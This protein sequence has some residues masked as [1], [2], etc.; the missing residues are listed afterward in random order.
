[1]RCQPYNS[2]TVSNSGSTNTLIRCRGDVRTGRQELEVTSQSDGSE[3]R[4]ANL[5]EKSTENYTG[6]MTTAVIDTTL[7]DLYFNLPAVQLIMLYHMIWCIQMEI[8]ENPPLWPY[9]DEYRACRSPIIYT[10]SKVMYI[11]PRLT[12]VHDHRNVQVS[13]TKSFL[14][15]LVWCAQNKFELHQIMYLPFYSMQT[16]CKKTE[17]VTKSYSFIGGGPDEAPYFDVQF[18]TF[19]LYHIVWCVQNELLPF[20]GLLFSHHEN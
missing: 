6:A 18:L 4:L 15:D 13:V 20:K 1:M 16:H 3:T 5:V 8:V 12:W 10:R 7:T 9:A 19:A 14:G 11:L 17:K 2:K